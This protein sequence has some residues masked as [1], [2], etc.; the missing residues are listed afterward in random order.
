MYVTPL[1]NH[2]QPLIR[3]ELTDEV[4]LIGEPCPCGSVLR[5]IDDIQGRADDVFIYPNGGAVHPLAFR[6]PLG[7][8]RNIL[9]YQVRQTE[10]GATIAIRTQGQVE[11]E[12][13]KGRL[14]LELAKLGLH[15]PALCV[16]SRKYLYTAKLSFY[17]RNARRMTSHR[18][19]GV[20][21]KL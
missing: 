7:R 6:S 20:T 19:L 1:F 18:P 9:E 8:E 17:A 11:I 5:R 14:E 21:G 4:T 15:N 3:Y 16:A 12:E 10:R 2:V 13:L